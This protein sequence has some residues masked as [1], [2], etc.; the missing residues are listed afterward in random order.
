MIYSNYVF[1]SIDY[2]M[3]ANLFIRFHHLC[4]H[5]LLVFFYSFTDFLLLFF[6]VLFLLFFLFTSSSSVSCTLKLLTRFMKLSLSI[7]PSYFIPTLEWTILRVRRFFRHIIIL[8][9]YYN[10]YVSI[11]S[12]HFLSIHFVSIHF[13]SIHFVSIY[14]PLIVSVHSQ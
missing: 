11:V 8:S 9:A 10:M 12:I 4:F 1:L 7:M 13:L 3:L 2:A 14:Y 6:H 5:L